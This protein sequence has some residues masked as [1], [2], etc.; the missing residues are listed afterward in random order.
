M[1][2]MTLIFYFLTD[3][4]KQLSGGGSAEKQHLDFSEIINS[5]I[6]HILYSAFVLHSTQHM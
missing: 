2:F 5:A 6:K 3:K 4:S 1:F